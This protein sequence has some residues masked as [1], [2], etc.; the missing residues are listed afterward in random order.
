MIDY[1]VFQFDANHITR[2]ER[3]VQAMSAIEPDWSTLTISAKPQQFGVTLVCHPLLYVEWWLALKH[4]G[5][6]FEHGMKRLTAGYNTGNLS[7]GA[8]GSQFFKTAFDITTCLRIE[9][10]PEAFAEFCKSMGVPQSQQ[11]TDAAVR[12]W[13]ES[14]IKLVHDWKSE[15]RCLVASHERDFMERY[16]YWI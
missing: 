16:D 12:C 4:P 9:D 14:E 5:Q 8:I 11:L 6:P 15:W 1:T 3:F 10:M 7:N 2:P 13:P